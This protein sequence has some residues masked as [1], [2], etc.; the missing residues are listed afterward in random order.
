MKLKYLYK[1]LSRTNGGGGGKGGGSAPPPAPAAAPPPPPTDNS[2][3]QDPAIQ[4]EIERQRSLRYKA[5]Q[6]GFAKE[7]TGSG[8]SVV[9]D[10]NKKTLLGA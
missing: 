7:D 8:T 3:A 4:A 1:L 2:P 9:E 6:I 5:G 10:S